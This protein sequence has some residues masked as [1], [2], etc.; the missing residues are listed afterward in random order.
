MGI[1]Y[2]SR[3][4][5]TLCFLVVLAFSRVAQSYKIKGVI[6]DEVSKATLP[7]ASVR[8]FSCPDSTFL[9]CVVSD[10]D[11]RFELCGTPRDYVL[12]FEF[13]RYQRDAKK[14]NLD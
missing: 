8:L 6:Q 3:L 9:S 13:M 1:P 2:T 12:L 4:F 7:F 5:F 10:L 11:G 14:V